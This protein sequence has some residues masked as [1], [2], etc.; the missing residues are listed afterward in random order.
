[1]LTHAWSV[2]C[3]RVIIDSETNNVSLINIYERIT[4]PNSA[5]D[6]IPP[7]AKGGRFDFSFC[8]MSMWTREIEKHVYGFYRARLISPEGDSI[9]TTE[10]ER[11]EIE[12][13]MRRLRT[14][15]V[16]EDMV[17]TSPGIYHFQIQFKDAE[18]RKRWK[19]VANVPLEI[20]VAQS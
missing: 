9:R 11:I 20:F 13:P 8:L 15:L 19:A 3:E 14:K 17:F 1:M 2:L 6:Q 7:D 10:E 12:P 18:K 4:L 16:N 5:I